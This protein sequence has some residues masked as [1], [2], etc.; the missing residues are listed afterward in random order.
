MHYEGPAKYDRSA[1]SFNLVAVGDQAILLLLSDKRG[2]FLLLK[3]QLSEAF[4][5]WC[6]RVELL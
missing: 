1:A 3:A 4:E 5:R 6:Y 2:F